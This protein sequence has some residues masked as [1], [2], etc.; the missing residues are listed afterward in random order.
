MTEDQQPDPVEAR[1]ALFDQMAAQ[2]RLNKD[3]LFGGAFLMVPPDGDPFS[4]LML[5]QDQASIFWAAVQT[6]STMALATLEQAQRQQ[7][8]GRR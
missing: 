6:L 1:A 2:I 4:S 8:F 5:N 3:A 7:G